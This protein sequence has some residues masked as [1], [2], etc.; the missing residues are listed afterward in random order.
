M[1]ARLVATACRGPAPLNHSSYSDGQAVRH[2]L[3]CMALNG[4]RPDD[5]LSAE[6]QERGGQHDEREDQQLGGAGDEGRDP[7]T[8][9]GAG[10]S[11]QAEQVKAAPVDHPTRQVGQRANQGDGPNDCQGAGDRDFLVLTNEID[12]DRNGQHRPARAE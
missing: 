2:D 12:Q 8:Y 1:I 4:R 9:P 7:R 11:G 5:G 6:H 3:P 10:H